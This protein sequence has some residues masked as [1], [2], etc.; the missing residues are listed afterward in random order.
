MKKYIF[1]LTVVFSALF[2]GCSINEKH[3]EQSKI[4]TLAVGFYGALRDCNELEKTG[5]FDITRNSVSGA[6]VCGHLFYQKAYYWLNTHRTVADHEREILHSLAKKP[7][8]MIMTNRPAWSTYPKTVQDKIIQNVENG[9]VLSIFAPEKKLYEK[10]SKKWRKISHVFDFQKYDEKDKFK[11]DIYEYGKGK[12]IIQPGYIDNRFGFFIPN[13]SQGVINY[14]AVRYAELLRSVTKGSSK[15]AKSKQYITD[16]NGKFFENNDN[17]PEGKYFSITENYNE[18]GNIASKQGRVFEKKYAPGIDN[19]KLLS[20]NEALPGQKIKIAAAYRNGSRNGRITACIRDTYDRIIIEKKFKNTPDKI[21]LDFPSASITPVNFIDVCYFD[22]NGN[23]INKAS[24]EITIPYNPEKQ[25]FY[26]ITWN[27]SIGDSARH[28]EYYNA[29]KKAGFDA[30]SNMNVSPKSIRNTALAN[31]RPIPYTA[32]FHQSKIKNLLDPKI[33]EAKTQTAVLAAELGKKY[34]ALAHSIGDEN[35]VSSFAPDGRFCNTPQAWQEFRKFLQKEYKSLADLNSAWNKKYKNWDEI[36]FTTEAEMFSYDYPACWRDYRNFVSYLFIQRQ[37]E[38]R[39]AVK[40][41]DPAVY[42]GFEGAEQYSSYDGY[43]WYDYTKSFDMNNVY[44]RSF[45]DKMLPNKIFNGHAMRSFASK[46]NLTGLW[47][48]GVD[49]PDGMRIVP[50]ETLFSGMNSIWWWHSTIIEVEN[51][52]LDFNL[53]ENKIFSAAANEI[54]KIKNGPATILR[55]AEIEKPLIAIYYSTDNFHASTLSANLGNHVNSMG[56]DRVQWSRNPSRKI[57]GNEPVFKKQWN[58]NLPVGH[59]APAFKSFAALLKDMNCDF[60]VIDG[61]EIANG[62]LKSCKILILPF[63]E[64]LS[65]REAEE[66]KKFVR[67]GG[68]VIADYRTGI[69]YENCNFRKDGVLDEVF[70]I[71]QKF[72]FAIKHKIENVQ[73]DCGL[74]D[75]VS[76]FR[77]PVN[78][79]GK[80][81]AAADN[82]SGISDS[83]EN[84]FILNKYGKGHALYFNFDFYEYFE[85]RKENK[86]TAVKEFLRHYFIRNFDLPATAVVCDTNDIPFAKTKVMRFKDKESF[87]AGLIFDKNIHESK[88]KQIVK[89]PML[90]KGHLY[91]VINQKYLGFSDTAVIEA[92]RGYVALIASM[93]R[94]I[95]PPQLDIPNSVKRGNKFKCL[96]RMPQQPQTVSVSIISPLNQTVAYYGKCVYL[97]NGTGEFEFIPALNDICGQWQIEVQ[98]TVSGEKTVK[99]FE[100]K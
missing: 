44:A 98:D 83:G 50:W 28:K 15:T 20:A 40:K 65:D 86:E 82:A 91:D 5:F 16:I 99:T 69:R 21:E 56:C 75:W 33:A 62:D 60:M 4:K 81:I 49:Y 93:P 88:S 23:L 68:T 79:V 100:I 77:F 7:Q 52:P 54:R 32:A 47:M 38:I 78:F 3:I 46:N 80:N 2:S 51:S 29:L 24:L 59:Y 87:Y 84:V 1:L 41:I 19:I 17:L 89:I 35:Y 22:N 55:N 57:V 63:V 96:I 45:N 36:R 34:G 42:V 39:D 71:K 8:L 74:G 73:I 14:V 67:N 10:L 53:K 76:Y 94:K 61:K 70:G 37:R 11:F 72:P 43:N 9:M 58:D 6:L 30:F 26:F 64:A 85:L 25:D 66:I 27:G 13:H 92:E 95:T 12:I 97:A 90:H 48:N 18:N 31:M